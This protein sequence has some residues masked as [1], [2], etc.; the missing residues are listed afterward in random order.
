MDTLERETPAS[1][2]MAETDERYEILG[3]LGQGGMGCVYRA[4]DRTTGEIVALKALLDCHAHNPTLVARFEREAE[5]ASRIRHANVAI[6]H[7]L[8]E[9]GERRFLKM[10]FV[11][12]TTL[13]SMLRARKKLAPQ[14]AL[15]LFRQLC[16]GV[17][18]A[19]EAGLVHRD[20]KPSNVLISSRDGR[21]VILDFGVAKS[22]EE[23]GLTKNGTLLGSLD[24][25][26][27]EQLSGHDVTARADVYSLGVLLYEM[28]TGVCP[29][30]VPHLTL[31]ER[32]ELRLRVED[33]RRHVPA[34]PAVVADVIARCLEPH[35]DDRF[36][37]PLEIL[38]FLT[39]R[40]QGPEKEDQ[41]HVVLV[42][43]SPV[44]VNA[45]PL[46]VVVAPDGDLRDG[47]AALLQ[48]LGCR[49]ATF[50]DG[51]DA[52][53]HSLQHRCHVLVMSE[54]ATGM[55]PWEACAVMRRYSRFDST[56]ILVLV[57]GVDEA[58]PRAQQAGISEL[59]AVP[60]DTDDLA[61]RIRE[62]LD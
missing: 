35:P 55:D 42:A 6:V 25:M 38:E 54:V 36:A 59:V 51:R 50:D 30:R 56:R 60:L 5:F 41:S 32:M 3:P 24:Y 40:E 43:G 39:T 53:I 34:L 19:H 18:A 26:S 4:R 33:P 20:L 62:L 1:G 16:A 2:S 29:L 17:Q 7:G 12:G 22:V 13:E 31:L 9:Q 44:F 23:A 52:L 49:V 46:A 57:N 45:A 28:V 11:E 58:R 27:P 14:V 61:R 37:T 47:V 15:R 8:V 48:R 10:E 21:A